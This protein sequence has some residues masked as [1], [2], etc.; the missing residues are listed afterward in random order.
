MK[1][2]YKRKEL[3]GLIGGFGVVAFLGS[4]FGGFYSIGLALFLALAIWI[5]GATLVI[6][7]TD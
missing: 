3:M 6:V 2:R 4:I 7:L 1:L 5:V